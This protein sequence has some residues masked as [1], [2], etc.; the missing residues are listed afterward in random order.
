VFK[1]GGAPNYIDIDGSAHAGFVNFIGGTDAQETR[2]QL[3]DALPV[4]VR[5]V[6]PICGGTPE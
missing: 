4:E 1:L 3:C 2:A 5:D 6:V